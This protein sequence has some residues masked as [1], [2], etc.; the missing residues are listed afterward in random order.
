[1]PHKHGPEVIVPMRFFASCL[2]VARLCLGWF[3]QNLQEF[4]KP[5]SNGASD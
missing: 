1:M 2:S 5:E 4:A 3:R